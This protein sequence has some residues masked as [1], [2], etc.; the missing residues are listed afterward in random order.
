MSPWT[1]IDDH[2]HSHPKALAAWRAEPASI[3]LHL[4]ALSHSTAYLTDGHVDEEFIHT[5]F[6]SKAKRD[7]AIGA[8]VDS[9]LWE[10][11]GD[12]YVIHDYLKYHASREVQTA[13][14]EAR[15]AKRRTNRETW[16]AVR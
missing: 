15:E 6:H 9:G 12:G 3:G 10:R 1:K 13:R 4:F 11:N 5:L 8:L 2:F 7:K 14:M 16:N